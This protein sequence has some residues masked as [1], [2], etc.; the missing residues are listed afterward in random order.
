MLN[1]DLMICETFSG[2]CYHGNEKG[3]TGRIN[4]D[5]TQL[6]FIFEISR[7]CSGTVSSLG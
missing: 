2:D 1:S 7:S 4:W 5:V 6:D 3:A